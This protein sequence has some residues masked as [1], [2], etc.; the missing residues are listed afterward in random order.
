MIRKQLDQI[1]KKNTNKPVRSKLLQITQ[2]LQNRKMRIKGQFRAER[3]T[4]KLR[5]KR[6]FL[7]LWIAY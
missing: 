7:Y 1:K 6:K 2:V 3:I 5:R 4:P